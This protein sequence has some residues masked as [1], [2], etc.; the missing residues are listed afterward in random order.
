MSY[1]FTAADAKDRTAVCSAEAR[2]TDPKKPPT[3]ADEVAI[4][5]DLIAKL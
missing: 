3:T 4:L 1:Q 5:N 2:L